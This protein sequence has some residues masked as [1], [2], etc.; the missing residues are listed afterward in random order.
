MNLKKIL[1]AV[2]STATFTASIN[3][4]AAIPA[5]VAGTRYESPIQVLNALKIMIGDDNGT[6][7]PEDTITRA[8]AAKMAIHAMGM[9]SM[10]EPSKGNNDFLD[11]PAD[12][13]SNG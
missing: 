8:E 11:V 9:E 1:C 2:I 10:A 3:A 6:F 13:W 4:L 5:D 7:R 12:H